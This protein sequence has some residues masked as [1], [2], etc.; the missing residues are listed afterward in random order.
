MTVDTV[1]LVPTTEHG[2]PSGN[3]DGSSQDFVADPAKAANYYRGRGGLQ[4]VIFPVASVF[5]SKLIGA[6]K[7]DRSLVTK[8]TCAVPGTLTPVAVVAFV[9]MS[10]THTSTEFAAVA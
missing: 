4:T 3:Y 1:V 9:V 6:V 5:T 8:E 7:S 10:G 2:V